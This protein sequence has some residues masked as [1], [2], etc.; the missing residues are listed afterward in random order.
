MTP[1]NAR[2]RENSTKTLGE[3]VAPIHPMLRTILDSGSPR[4]G[5][6]VG[7]D[8]TPDDLI[9]P[10]ERGGRRHASHS[11]DFKHDVA[12]LGLRGSARATRR[13]TFRSL[14]L[15]AGAVPHHLDLITHPNP[16]QAKDVYRRMNILWPA[17]CRAVECIRIAAE[18]VTTGVTVSEA[19]RKSPATTKRCGAG[20]WRA[21]QDSN[22][23]PSA[24]EGGAGVPHRAAASRKHLKSAHPAEARSRIRR[25]EPHQVARRLLTPLLTRRSGCSRHYQEQPRGPISRSGRSPSGSA[26]RRRPCTR[27]AGGANSATAASPTRSE[28]PRLPSLISRSPCCHRAR[29][30]K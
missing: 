30:S 18:G 11:N 28:C 20:V 23:W 15:E 27:S 24:P 16:T 3:R 29:H 14:A 17:L 7:R 22:L 6:Y 9:V 13:A 10:A 12:A 21:I 4:A 25:I 8:P 1:N 2:L 26:S 5:V 19:K